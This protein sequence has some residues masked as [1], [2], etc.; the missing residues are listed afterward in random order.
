MR[1]ADLLSHPASG[2]KRAGQR[3]SWLT[4]I[5]FVD[6]REQYVGQKILPNPGEHAKA[7]DLH[8]NTIARE[9]RTHTDI[10]RVTAGSR[11]PDLAGHMSTCF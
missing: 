11:P 10:Q 4:Q 7:P 8:T 2:N 9:A 1:S 5:S 3:G 6:R